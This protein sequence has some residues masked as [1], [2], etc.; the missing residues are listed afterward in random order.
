[1]IL[2]SRSTG[3]NG[4]VPMRFSFP[5]LLAGCWTVAAFAVGQSSDQNLPSA[6]SATVQQKS[7]AK[8]PAP[9]D[10]KAAS[11]QKHQQKPI[12]ELTPTDNT[13]QTT[14]PSG[15]NT[16]P[17]GQPAPAAPSTETVPA[18]V[19]PNPAQP[20]AQATPQLEDPP[21][22]NP[23]E[24]PITEIIRTVNEVRVIFT[25]TDKHGR[26]IK[27]MKRDDFRVVDDRKPADRINS[28]RSE[29]DLPLQVGLL[30]DASNSIRDR[31][32]FE[33]EA[34]IEFLNSMIRP[35]YDQ[36]FTV[37]FDSTPDVTQDF[38]D[39]TELLSKGVRA[40]KAGGG[41]AMYDALYY[42]CRDKL[43]KHDQAGPVRRAIIL[44][45]DGDDNSS[46]VTREESI[47]MAQRA[48]VIVY[49]ISTNI[50][51]SKTKSDKVL[52]RIAEATGGRAFF[53][54]QIRDV[55]DAFAS[56]QDELRS[57]YAM[58]YRPADFVADGHFRTIEI[59]A[60]QK[61]FHVRTRK[62]YYAPKR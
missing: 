50:T 26:Y 46:H 59:L 9:S 27:D 17:S 5:L 39:N 37:G 62:G 16:K 15:D 6:P 61:A 55:S 38:T 8:Q 43:M 14:P 11:E 53:P 44:V 49:T 58:T 19:T 30:I 4:A 34:A 31:F 51:G 54:F 3:Y 21:K 25:V 20:P 33:Q 60:Q 36:A 56:I 13:K 7:P 29:T 42:A 35:R 24:P 28:F 1:V 22:S 48:E 57:Q 32:K 23:A 10:S 40:L 45:S 12:Q 18:T 41:T 47:E 2:W 52:E